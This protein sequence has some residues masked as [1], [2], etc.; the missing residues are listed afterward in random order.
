MLYDQS[1]NGPLTKELFENPPARYRGAPFWAWNTVLE[2]EELLRQIDCLKEMGFGGFFMHSRSGMATPY[3]SRE[4]MDLVHACTDHAKKT[5]LMACLYD[6]DRWSSGFAGGLVTQNPEYRQK[7]I[8]LSREDPEKMRQ[9]QEREPRLLAAYDIVFDPQDR[10]ASFRRIPAE[11]EAAGEKWYLYVL[12]Q[13]PSGWY[14]GYTYVDVLNPEATEA[15]IRCTHEAYKRELGEDFGGS[16]PVI[17]TDEPHFGPIDLKAYARDGRDAEFPW[18]QAFRSSFQERFGY[19]ILDHI[20]ELVWNLSDA[21]PSRARYHYYA[22]ASELIA[23]SYNDRIGDWC[24]QNGLGFTGHV[25]NEDSLLAQARGVG[26][27]MRQYRNYTLPGVDMLADEH[28]F[29]TVKQAQSAAHQYGRAGVTSELYGVNGWDF[30]FRGH[31][32]QG[33]W[34]AALGVTFR[35]P[36]LAWVSMQGSAKRD[37]PASISYQSSWFREYGFIEDHFARVNT[38]MT[39]G[40]PVVKTAVI[41]PIES[42][43]ITAAVREHTAAAARALEE[44]FRSLTEWLLR[45]QLDFDF[46]SESLLPELYEET[47]EGFQVG[48][49]RYRAVVVPPL[50]TIRSTTLKALAAFAKKGGKVIVCGP[51][52]ACVDGAPVSEAAHP[53]EL[54]RLYSTAAAVPFSEAALLEALEPERELRIYG[55]DGQPRRD[56]FYQLRADG[57]ER[58]LF[59]AH[60]DAHSDAS[61]RMDGGDCRCDDLRLEIKGAW[62]PLLCDT[63]TGEIRELSYQIRRGPSGDATLLSLPCYSLDSFLLHLIPGRAEGLTL[64][65]AELLPETALAVPDRAAYEW[66]EPNALV[67]DLCEWSLD[68]KTWQPREEMLRID[69]AIR[70]QLHWPLANGRDMQPWC[71]SDEAPSVF[72]WLRFTFHSEVPAACLLGYER[73]EALWLNGEPVPVQKTGYYVDKAIH[74]LALP[75][76]RRGRNEL[77]LRAPISPRISLE[78]YFLLGDFGVRPEG[79]S[80]AVTPAPDTLFYGSVT[81]QGLPF[82]GGAITYRIPFTCPAAGD[83]SVTADYYNGALISARLDGREAGRIVLPPYTLTVPEVTAGEHLLELT[84]YA[85]RINTFGALHLCR[86]VSWKGPGMWYQE[87]SGW[88]YEYQLTDVGLMKK[89]VLT[90]RPARQG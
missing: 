22:H 70:E 61:S 23:T 75:P 18:T 90:L 74:T 32:A 84:L 35:V 62:Q 50:V 88:A 67:L 5:G 58:W 36:H 20:P 46:I 76:L 2:K 21:A 65:Q 51:V 41:H 79:S 11:A 56:L 9:R 47:D 7:T 85:S 1:Q 72:P 25:L 81:G 66:S 89:P 17:F 82:Y 43:W 87:G 48:R 73:L 13:A 40:V 63:L 27:A 19:D 52:P 71:L 60:S 6:E 55:R 42:A 86:P 10:L 37:Y 69:Q 28:N 49:M 29:T 53:E 44:Q 57:E 33:D 3:L 38:A 64:P 24:R 30:D 14:N 4:F 45:G 34:Q 31:K 78:N 26:E 8:C 68:G 39:R 54:R 59:I 77:L 15:F 12:L 83:L 80:A 16:V